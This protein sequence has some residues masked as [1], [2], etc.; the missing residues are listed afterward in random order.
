MRIVIFGAAGRLGSA[1]MEK[2]LEAGHYVRAF[3]RNPSRISI[4]N[5]NLEVV[6]GDALDRKAVERA[7]L[8]MDSVISTMASAAKN[9]PLTCGTENIIG[10]MKKYGVKRLI[11]TA[12]QAVF[13]PGDE[14]DARYRT[15]NLIVRLLIPSVYRDVVGSVN[16]VRTSGTEWTVVRVNRTR[17][18]PPAGRVAAGSVNSKM[19][20]RLTRADAADFIIRELSEKKYLGQA[21]AICSVMKCRK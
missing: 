13:Q 12:G 19:K 8:G 17:Y 5:E 3:V 7:V 4:M 18:K 1:V 16:T 11:V 9:M 6:K 20:M 15:L 21:P 14:P 10:A 2:A